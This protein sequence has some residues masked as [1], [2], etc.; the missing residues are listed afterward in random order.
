M[1]ERDKNE[2]PGPDRVKDPNFPIVGVGASAGGVEALEGLFKGM[3]ADPGIAIVVVTHL[4]PQR[5]SVLHEIIGRYT[6][7]SVHKAVDDVEVK[8][9][10]VYVL[11]AD[12]LIGITDGRLQVSKIDTGHR[13]RKPIDIF[14]SA[15]A[16]D[17]GEGAA[18]VILSGLDGDGTLGTKAVKERGGL[19][20][21]QTPNGH[22]PSYSSMPES[23]IGTGYVDF[24]IPVEQ[25]GRK[26]AEF[27]RSLTMLDDIAADSSWTEGDNEWKDARQQIYGLLRVQVGH[28]F[29]GYKTR[30]FLRRVH[31]R[32]QIVQLNTLDSYIERLRQDPEE[33]RALFRDLLINVTNFFRDADAFEALKETVIP[34]LFEGRG[35]DDTVRIWVPGCATGEEVFSIAMLMREHMDCLTSIPRVQ[36]FATDIDEH[37]LVVARA[38]RYPEA[39]MDTVSAERRRR[40]FTIDGGSF[41]VTKDVR[42]LCIF[43]PHS[44]IRD[45]PFSRIDLVS[46]RNLL[47]YFG[48]E[49]QGQVI[50][51]FHYALRPGG[52]LFLGTSENVNQF[53][54]FFTPVEK[55]HRIFR[56]RSNAGVPVRLPMAINGLLQTAVGR[57][58]L[59]R[60]GPVPGL[61][62]R[63]AIES[64]VLERFGPAFVVATRE[65]EIVYF[66]ANTGK[67]LEQ[68]AGAP[69]RQLLTMARKGM[70]YDLRVAFR[71]AIDTGK[72][73]VREHLSVEGDAHT[74]QAVRLT[75]E[76]IGESNE[77]EPLYLVLF[78]DQEP[79]ADEVNRQAMSNESANGLAAHLDRELAETKERLQSQ[80]E[81]YETALEELKSSNEELVSVNEELQSTNEELEA[82]KEELQSLNEELNT[83]NIELGAKVE[84]LDQA[85]GDLHNLFE[86]T[87]IATVFLDKNLHIR[88]FTPAVT[89]ILHILPNDRGRPI[90]DLAS[91]L[92]LPQL[93]ADVR[94]VLATGGT[95]EHKIEHEEGHGHYLVRLV[96][97][98]DSDQRADGVVVTFIDV[99]GL[100]QAEA[101][102]RTLIAELNHRVK[103]MLTVAI[104]IAEQTSKSTT[105]VDGFKAAYVERLRAMSRS[106]ELLS[107]ENWTDAAMHELIVQELGPFGEARFS[108][109]G[110]QVRLKP[111]QAM[112]VGMILHELATNASKYGAL[113]Q[114]KGHVEI[115]WSVNGAPGDQRLELAWNEMDGPEVVTPGRLGFG[116]KLIELE[117]SFNLGGTSSAAFEKNGL[118]LVMEFPLN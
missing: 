34:Q 23:A 2:M 31:R 4:N 29:G 74:N 116:M 10:C 14:L 61:A 32:M 105:T 95:I 35:A 111:P 30:T 16:K 99:T 36:I 55:K 39:L 37:A 81:E 96:P 42:D 68:L 25:M 84:A 87:Q 3:P 58:D 102:Q 7:L 47:I 104:S 110:P 65:G 91:R 83:V 6:Q 76:S 28:D 59:H 45:P 78:E 60:S 26:L 52:Y 17:Q 86:S 48:P 106:Y 98:R 44:V 1:A 109:A 73:I 103:N 100:A 9:N 94:Q 43:S 107:R 79:K 27:A 53:A 38:G 54:E 46:C 66:S 51:I 85:N 57:T 93:A 5:E 41:V 21:A 15:L 64:R 62:W 12:A 88:R 113:S 114:P 13:E 82:S 22:G 115:E 63:Q 108:V 90:T 77:K 75:V 19:T 50:P 97:Y 24:A 69:S 71:E 49:V 89:R 101:H 70:R 112:S 56:S 118:R 18:S 40:F 8:P 67:Y 20:M 117:V 92:F 11:P 72:T 80:I 33:V